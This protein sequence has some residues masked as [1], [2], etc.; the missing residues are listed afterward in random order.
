MS[1][2][3]QFCQHCE[4][5]IT[6]LALKEEGFCCQG[7]KAA[8]AVISGLGLKNY[9]QMRLTNPEVRNI[10]P[11]NFEELD[12]RNFAV[13]KDGIW[14]VLLA[15]DGLHCAACVW[16]IEMVLKK[17]ENVRLAR[18]N[19]TKKYLKLRFVGEIEDGVE[20]VDK[21]RGLGYRLLPFDAEVLAE[22]ERKY[23]NELV[24]S[25]AV[26][27]FGAGNI[28]LFSI[29]L[30]FYG[31]AMGAAMR[32]FLHYFSALIAVPAIIYSSRVFFYSA[33]K[34]LRARRGNM[35]V[36]IAVALF[37]T[38]SISFFEVFQ[39]ADHVYFDSAMMLCFFLLIGRYL[40]FKVR[41]K[42]F[43]VGREFSLLNANYARIIDENGAV[44]VIAAKNLQKNMVLQVALGEKV[45]VDAVLLDEE[46]QIDNS[47]VSG[48]SLPKKIR[49]GEVIFAGAINLGQNI[50]L[51]VVKKP[52]ESLIAQIRDVVEEIE[53][54][55]GKYVNLADKLARFYVPAVHFLALFSFV[56]WY[57]WREVGFDEAILSGVTVLIITCPCA[58][59]L[60]VPITQS[61]LIS[62]LMKKGIVVK[63]GEAIEKIAEIEKFVFDK[64]GTLTLGRP[65][66]QDFRGDKRL[67]KVAASMARK[68]LHP[69][70][71]ALVARYDG[72]DFFDL[73]VTEIA[74]KGLVSE[75]EGQEVKL[76]S[77]DFVGVD[78]KSEFSTLFLRISDEIAAFYFED[79]VKNDAG[80]MLAGLAGEAILLSGDNAGVVRKIAEKLGISEFY[81]QKNPLEKIAVA[82]AMNCKIAA[83]GDGVNDA[84]LL[85]LGHVS[86]S[87]L[88]GSNLTKNVADVIINSQKLMP[89]LEFIKLSKKAVLLMKQNLFL[90]LIYNLIALPFA[91]LGMV[92]PLFAALAMSFSSILVTLNSMRILK[93]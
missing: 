57:F 82:K 60:A 33:F 92:T 38:L 42:A 75:L 76:G 71:L 48:E 72:G 5:E 15:V 58:L 35:D 10:R 67:F 18:V 88:K 11:E 36:A 47:I 22:E 63:N 74:G 43:D 28:M 26:A 81:F 7:C 55:K 93:K 79:K 46:A 23:N 70:S 16:L 90:A 49:K 91:F 85:A 52:E 29:A 34:A 41:K 19:L 53:N 30:W 69:L 54:H 68:S 89:I 77:G 13:K 25:L 20:L 83:F 27:G 66:L 80:E 9:Y 1:S 39:G 73:E 62:M 61:L 2:D 12:L 64:T 37:L 40:D 4:L 86:F 51:K 84:G 44:K 14:E 32:G 17:C 6:D 3:K 65:V 8:F 78:E 59:A 50:T 24:K 87:F 45:A 21:V 56:F 31:D